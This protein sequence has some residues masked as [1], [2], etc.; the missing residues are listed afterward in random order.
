MALLLPLLDAL[1]LASPTN[2]YGPPPDGAPVGKCGEAQFGPIS[3]CFCCCGW[4]YIVADDP[5]GGGGSD[6]DGAACP[7]V[8]QSGQVQAGGGDLLWSWSPGGGGPGGPTGYKGGSCWVGGG[9]GP[10]WIGA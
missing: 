3:C 9:G 4:T 5:R 8:P 1:A 10:W 6:H 7:R 2:T